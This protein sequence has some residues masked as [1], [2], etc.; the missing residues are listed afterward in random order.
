MCKVQY[1]ILVDIVLKLMT[2][3]S[4]KHVMKLALRQ[5]LATADINILGIGGKI[6]ALA[7]FREGE[8]FLEVV[9][10]LFFLVCDRNFSFPNAV[11]LKF[12]A[13]LQ[14]ESANMWHLLQ[15]KSLLCIFLVTRSKI[16][17]HF[18]LIENDF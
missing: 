17:V 5:C 15:E 13:K 3:T 9:S 4:H 2:V 14:Q 12:S 8:N 11:I 18:R 6:I 1:T 10:G 16:H 7:F